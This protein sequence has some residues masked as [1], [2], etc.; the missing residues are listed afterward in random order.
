MAT[1][2]KCRALTV[3]GV[4]ALAAVAW[5]QSG[6]SFIEGTAVGQDGKPLVGA[7]VKIERTDVKGNYQV[8]TDKKGKWFH[9]GLPLG[10][11][12]TIHLLV[13][14]REVD[15]V[16]GIK[17]KMDGTS[18]IALQEKGASAAA[19]AP[20]ESGRAMSAAEKAEL[21]KK[22]KEREQAMAKNKALN[23]AFTAG[24]AALTAKQYD[25]AITQL[26]KGTEL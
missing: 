3:L 12:F 18:G 23:D 5:A 19:A 14:D 8:K 15:A 7:M 10:A 6:T 4:L 2:I 9:A 22:L 13:G 26:T 21:D 17:T 24:M 11:S 16:Q 1:R 25:E 20:N